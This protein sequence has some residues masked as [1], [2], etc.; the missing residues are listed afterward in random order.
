M[1]KIPSLKVGVGRELQA[2]KVEIDA[3]CILRADYIPNAHKSPLNSN[4]CA[5]PIGEMLK[6]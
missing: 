1:G 5:R 6:T 4:L 2:D 3:I